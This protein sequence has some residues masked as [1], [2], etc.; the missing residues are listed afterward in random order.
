MRPTT[1]F[2]IA[3]LLVLALLAEGTAVQGNS[4]VQP[5]PPVRK[6]R[7][8]MSPRAGLPKSPIRAPKGVSPQKKSWFPFG[9]KN[10]KAAAP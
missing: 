4:P 3:A 7:S 1:R 8:I 6:P 2:G 10:K 9:N 5:L